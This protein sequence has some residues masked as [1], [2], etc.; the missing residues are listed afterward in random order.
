GGDPESWD[1]LSVDKAF[2]EYLPQ[3]QK[4]RNI[5]DDTREYEYRRVGR[6]LPRGRVALLIKDSRPQTRI[7]RDLLFY[8]KFAHLDDCAKILFDVYQDIENTDSERGWALWTLEAIGTS[9]QRAT[10]KDDLLSGRL[11]TNKLIAAALPVIDWQSLTVKQLVDIFNT[12]GEEYDYSSEHIYGLEPM[13]DCLQDDL[14]PKSDAD[15]SELL[16]NA[17]MAAL[18]QSTPQKTWL[19]KAIPLCFKRLLELLPQNSTNYPSVCIDALKYINPPE[20]YEREKFRDIIARHTNLRWQVALTLPD[21]EDCWYKDANCLVTFDWDDLPELTRRAN[22]L[23][24]TES[25]RTIWFRNAFNVAFYT[26]AVLRKSSRT[27]AVQ[28]LAV[29]PEQ[30][31]RQEHIEKR[32]VQSITTQQGERDRRSKERRK[33]REERQESKANL[34]SDIEQ[35]RDG[36]YRGSLQRLID[37]SFNHSTDQ[38]R[39]RIDLDLI[40]KDFGQDISTALTAGLKTYWRTEKIATPDEHNLNG[41]RFKE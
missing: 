38:E 7:W 1:E 17:V 22:D 3:L 39:S 12:A 8:A 23:T 4:G 9:K 14:L 27:K 18:P 24:L 6:R 28:A 35:I 32:L 15:S 19:T 16:L 25:E 13:F 29:G 37:Y 41:T 36:S 33:K 34:L 11:K 5:Y 40:T 20:G 2:T 31:T 30:T 10:V 21:S 26:P